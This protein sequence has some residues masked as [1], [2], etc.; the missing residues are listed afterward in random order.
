MGKMCNCPRCGE[1]TYEKLATH[2]HCTGCLY[3]PD[4]DENYEPAIPK[5]A[6]KFMPKESEV[7]LEAFIKEKAAKVAIELPLTP[8][9]PN[10]EFQ[11]AIGM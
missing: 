5:W 11:T 3:S 1:R 6:M 7:S 4:L 2:S 10:Q 8:S 9:I